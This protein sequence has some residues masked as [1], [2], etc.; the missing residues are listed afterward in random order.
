M[1]LNL[2]AEQRSKSRRAALLQKMPLPASHIVFTAQYLGIDTLTQSHYMWIASA[3]LCDVLS[4]TLPVG[5]AVRKL[6]S[7]ANGAA[8]V[9]PQFYYNMS[10][11]ASQWEHPSLTHWRSVLAELQANERQQ[12]SADPPSAASA[13]RG[14]PG[15][16]KRTP[17][18][19]WVTGDV[20]A[21]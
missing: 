3:A 12:L 9:L 13:G 2:E 6:H 8:P 1:H 16:A 5:W 19:L 14:K 18:P 17:V 21:A 10:L 4:P 20:V 11:R 7:D 15:E